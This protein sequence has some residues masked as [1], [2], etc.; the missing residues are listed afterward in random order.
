MDH[1]P[2]RE[3]GAVP[4][5]LPYGNGHPS[6]KERI[7]MGTPAQLIPLHGTWVSPQHLSTGAFQIPR[8]EPMVPPTPSKIKTRIIGGLPPC[9]GRYPKL[10]PENAIGTSRSPNRRRGFLKC[11]WR[12][13]GG[14]R[15]TSE[16]FGIW[17]GRCGK[18]YRCIIRDVR[19]WQGRRQKP[20]LCRISLS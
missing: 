5:G 14:P 18:V 17:V 16:T 4:D 2:S 12:C 9:N 19:R 3:G 20:F 15:G 10:H 6:V 1:A 7:C 11:K 8:A 13:N